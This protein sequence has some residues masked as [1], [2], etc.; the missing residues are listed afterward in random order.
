MHSVNSR[1]DFIVL[2]RV[3]I[4]NGHAYLTGLDLYGA[5][6]KHLL[7]LVARATLLIN[8]TYKYIVCISCIR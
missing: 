4:C 3:R 1:C 2:L 5:E 7:Q 6:Q 8:T